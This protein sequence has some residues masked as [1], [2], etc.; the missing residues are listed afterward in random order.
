MSFVTIQSPPPN[1][2]EAAEAGSVA[3]LED[4]ATLNTEVEH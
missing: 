3:Q 1:R 2:A 4:I